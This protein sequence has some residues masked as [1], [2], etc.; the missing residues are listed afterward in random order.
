[1]NKLKVF[2]LTSL[3]FLFSGCYVGYKTIEN[4]SDIVYYNTVKYIDYDFSCSYCYYETYFCFYCNRIHVRVNHWCD[5][6]YRWYYNWYR[7]NYYQPYNYYYTH[8]RYRDENRHYVRDKHGLRNLGE[9]NPVR[10]KK[11]GTLQREPLKKNDVDKEFS[12]KRDNI[13]P[14]YPP[15]KKDDIKLKDPVKQDNVKSKYPS[16]KRND[17]KQSPPVKRNDVK[18]SPPVKRN[19]VKQS[20][21]VKR[22]DVKQSSPVKRDTIKKN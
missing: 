18:Q 7:V 4:E 10:E 12:V 15:V 13:K 16:V 9:R 21:P 20:P 11:P 1:M 3:F 2:F 8:T 5:N 17:V 6:H 19:D 14:K 22:N